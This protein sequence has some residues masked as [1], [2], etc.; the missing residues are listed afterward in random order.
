M[1]F[2]KLLF[3][4][5]VPFLVFDFLVLKHLNFLF[6]IQHVVELLMLLID[7]YA[8]QLVLKKHVLLL[9]MLLLGEQFDLVEL[10]HGGLQLG[11]NLV[12][13]HVFLL[14]AELLPDVVLLDIL[15]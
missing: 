2:S 11:L 3:D 1:N 6:L 9:L 7:V 4:V 13:F 5:F 10:V 8:F 12:V 14:K 15:V